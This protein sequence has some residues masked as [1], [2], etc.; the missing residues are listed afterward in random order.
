MDLDR[1]G[2]GQGFLAVVAIVFVRELP[3]SAIGK[4]LRRKLRELGETTT[5][6]VAAALAESAVGVEHAAR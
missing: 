6:S 5:V 3:K 2:E 1:Y 4:V